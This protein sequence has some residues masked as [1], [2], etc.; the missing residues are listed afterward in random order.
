MQ[1]HIVMFQMEIYITH[2]KFITYDQQYLA[3]IHSI[4]RPIFQTMKKEVYP[5]FFSLHFDIQSE[6]LFQCSE[7]QNCGCSAECGCSTRSLFQAGTGPL[8]RAHT[9]SP[10]HDRITISDVTKK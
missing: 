1:L 8:F 9:G 3:T 2:E 6:L 10:V 7:S 4:G 5:W